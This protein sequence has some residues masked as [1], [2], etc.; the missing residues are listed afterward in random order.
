VAIKEIKDRGSSNE[1]VLLNKEWEAEAKALDEITGLNH[2]N[3]IQRIAAITRG[4][5]HYFMFQWADG[6]SLGDF[7]KE[8]PRPR[9]DPEFIKEIVLQL[10]GLADALHELHTYEGSYRHGDLKPENILRFKDNTRVG[11]LKIADMGLAKHHAVATYLRP[12]TST[13]FGTV[14]YEP[15]EVIT[16][17]LSEEGRSRLY[18]IWSMGC[19]TLE[20]IVWLLYGYEELTKFNDSIK[21]SLEESS[22]YF[23]VDRDNSKLATV[24]PTV[25]AF[26]ERISKDRECTGNTA[27]RDLLEIVRERLL[28]VPLPQ[29]RP[30]T[31]KPEE[32]SGNVAVTDAD[33]SPAPSRPPG[34]SRATAKHFRNLLDDMIGKGKINERYWFTG[35]P[36]GGL[37]GPR[38]VPSIVTQSF[39]SPDS[40]ARPNQLVDRRTDTPQAGPATHLAPTQKQ[41]VSELYCL[42]ISNLVKDIFRSLPCKFS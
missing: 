18:D 6:G 42:I 8:E 28:V 3:I 36:R 15:P 31:L 10:R 1:Q 16:H 17:K 34:P 21:G 9:L 19:I 24:H 29:H 25:Q 2:K 12:A 35:T 14:R 38:I 26:M 32:R 22:P 13:R 40:A 37:R 30:S 23:M 20:L 39:L 11:I 4:N 27:M 41:N 7:W 33:D 5:K